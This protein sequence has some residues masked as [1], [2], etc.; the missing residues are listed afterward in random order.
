MIDLTTPAAPVTP[1]QRVIFWT[2]ALL[3][4][5]SRFAALAR[6]LWDWDEVLFCFGLRSYDV[7]SHHPHPPGF[8]VY[9]AAGKLMRIFIRDDFRALQAINLI[10]AVL[11]FPAVYYLAR[12]L[13]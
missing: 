8:P 6:T 13:R 5:L 11:V 3:C 10:A 2:V 9:I 7:T 4:A 12:Q 1:R